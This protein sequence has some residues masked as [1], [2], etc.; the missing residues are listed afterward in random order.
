VAAA[1]TELVTAV[2][3]KDAEN[4]RPEKIIVILPVS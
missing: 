2:K 4:K 1:F 3:R